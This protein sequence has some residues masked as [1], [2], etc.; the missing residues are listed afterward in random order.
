MAERECRLTAKLAIRVPMKLLLRSVTT[1]VVLSTIV[2]GQPI[3]CSAQQQQVTPLAEPL[4]KEDLKPTYLAIVECARRNQEAGCLAAR[5]LA[6]RLLDR[7]YVTSICKDTAFSV[8]LK[9]KT[10]PKN[11]FDRKELLVTK[12]DD[13]M[14]LCRGKEDAKPV[15]NTLG[16]GINKR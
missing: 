16:D 10:A 11:S 13:I 6:D 1:S 9:A 15:S 2:I 4:T 14:L 3:F 5:Q 8:T 12:A 7:P